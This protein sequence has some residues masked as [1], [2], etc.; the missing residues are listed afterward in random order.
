LRPA[1]V[2]SNTPDGD[3]DMYLICAMITSAKR[4]HWTSDVI[5]LD[6]EAAGLQ[7]ES[8][9]RWKVFT[10]EAAL[11]TGK[12]GIESVQS[13]LAKILPSFRR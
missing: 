3:C 5:L 13:S 7:A 11:V 10:I 4:S 6:W 9:L 1:L 2:L 8:I 12:R